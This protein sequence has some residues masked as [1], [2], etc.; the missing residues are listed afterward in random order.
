MGIYN[1][2]TPRSSPISV[3]AG[4]TKYF[5]RMKPA[6]AQPAVPVRGFDF[7]PQSIDSS[8]VKL[9]LSLVR[10]SASGTWPNAGTPTNTPRKHKDSDPDHKGTYDSGVASSDPTITSDVGDIYT[11]YIPPTQPFVYRF[12]PDELP[13]IQA[14]EEWCW[15]LTAGA[16]STTFHFN[17]V[18]EDA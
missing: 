2:K 14:G 9:V 5:G 4:A 8:D 1:L 13:V 18:L 15:V 11:W 3:N 16:D 10:L 7:T 6:S 17:I 12:P